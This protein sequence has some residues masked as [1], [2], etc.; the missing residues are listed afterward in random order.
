MDISQATIQKLL[1]LVEGRVQIGWSNWW[2]ENSKVLEQEIKRADFLKIKFKFCEG[3]SE[4]LA[5]LGIEHTLSKR[6]TTIDNEAIYHD[7][8][9]DENGNLSR[10]VL[11]KVWGGAIKQFHNGNTET[12]IKIFKDKLS[13]VLQSGQHE[14][15]N[16]LTFDIEK[17]M[18]F[19]KEFALAC[20]KIIADI[21]IFED[22]WAETYDDLLNSAIDRAK[23]IVAKV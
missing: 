7:S 15:L 5:K 4:Y 11:D 3:V 14:E 8:M 10:S 13:L 2:R 1:D 16:D 6:A 12:A 18:A 23:E 19:E 9:K 22:G 20:M 21:D 17:L